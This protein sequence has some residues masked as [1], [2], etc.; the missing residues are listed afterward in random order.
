MRTLRAKDIPSL[1]GNKV[2]TKED[3]LEQVSITDG[4]KSSITLPP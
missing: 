3:Y 1:A 2:A 4:V